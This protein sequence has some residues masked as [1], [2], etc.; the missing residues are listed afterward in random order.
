MLVHVDLETYSS[1]DL[2]AYGAYRYAASPD[3]LILLACWWE[4]GVHVA[5]DQDHSAAV[6][7]LL[8]YR[9]AGVQFVAHNAAF[10]RIVFTHALR[11]CLELE[12]DEWLPPHEW[13][14]TMAMAGELGFPQSLGKLAKALGAE[15]KDEAGTLLINWF[16]KPDRN[17]NRRLPEDHPEKWAKFVA[18]CEQD[19]ATLHDIHRRLLDKG[20]WPTQSEHQ[21]FMAD[22]SINDRGI[23]IDVPMARKAY[24][25]GQ[26]NTEEQKRRF[27]ELT[28]V[29]NPKSVQQ[30]GKWAEAEGIRNILPDM[31]KETIDRALKRDLPPH[32]QEA[33]HIRQ[34]LALAAPAK[35]GTALGSHV[36]GRLHG[37]LRFFGAHTGRWAGRG[38][39]VQNLPR[40]AFKLDVDRDLAI[41][42]LMAGEIISSEELKRLVRP[43][44]IGP[45]TV[46]DYSAIEARVIAWLAGE[47]WALEAFNDGRDIYVETAERMGGLTRAQ[48]KI[49]VL[50]LGYNGGAN[51][52]R[53]MAGDNDYID[54]D[55][56]KVRINQAPDEVLYE[57]LVNPWRK[58]NSRITRL[59]K[60]LD[61]RFRTGGPVGEH[62]SF[63]K[64]GRDRLLRL[65]SGRAICY[66]RCSVRVVEN[67]RE[68]L[69][70]DS[71]EGYRA[72]TY[73]G[74]LAE[75]A[76][77]AVARDIMAA[78]LVRL[79]AAGKPVVAH[80][81]DEILVE[82][83]H[84]LD[85]IKKI[86]CEPPD[87][88]TGLPIDGG[89]WTGLR[90]RKD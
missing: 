73:G 90:Y 80:V 20:G 50:A 62:L 46:V 35:F 61:A 8:K 47:Q 25:V 68:R 63:E 78:A 21:I 77:Q 65:P 37:T 24:K 32:I 79:E 14:D 69:T 13:E 86:M 51:S 1:V 83:E 59:W 22:Q 38:T 4:D 19:V 23:A 27:T 88:A 44:F 31:R 56:K 15:E 66:R 3:L 72:D 29:E 52:L 89:G 53:A 60:I 11:N 76:T 39:Q 55:G 41:A 49:A 64:D 33:L 40:A 71:P 43:L 26:I 6:S 82:G 28:G 75:N 9:E 81:H 74:R 30:L 87:W 42:D 58:A 17:G 10:E 16:C 36:N 48:G 70:F 18:Y 84:A 45:F 7:R 2:K 67:G 85:D 34:E 54:I 12:P 57:E 5:T